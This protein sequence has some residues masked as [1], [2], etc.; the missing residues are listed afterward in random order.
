M[1]ITEKVEIGKPEGSIGR[2]WKI[3]GVTEFSKPLDVARVIITKTP[4]T[5]IGIIALA[6]GHE[7]GHGEC[8]QD[9]IQNVDPDDQWRV[10]CGYDAWQS[11]M[12]A[13]MHA[14]QR[15]DT[16]S[17]DED[18]CHFVL[19]CMWSYKKA[20]NVSDGEWTTMINVMLAEMYSGATQ[21][22]HDYEPLEPDPGE[23]PRGCMPDFDDDDGGDDGDDDEGGGGDET[24][25]KPELD[26]DRKMPEEYEDE[27][28]K[29][30]KFDNGWLRQDILD[31]ITNGADLNDLAEEFKLDPTRLPPI[32]SSMIR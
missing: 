16:H 28:T 23:K 14:F 7:R 24:E 17:L 22:L 21:D 32:I 2:V 13:W 15:L 29:P 19:D 20:N 31:A 8:V 9:V 3:D 25:N 1:R 11:E 4:D 6:L 12:E 10:C 18:M 30:N 27:K 5:R 26:P